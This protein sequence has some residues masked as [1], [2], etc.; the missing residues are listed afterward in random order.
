MKS[1]QCDIATEL[2]R[3]IRDLTDAKEIVE[4]VLP[5]GSEHLGHAERLLRISR[6]RIR[7]ALKVVRQMPTIEVAPSAN[8]E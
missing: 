6:D 5:G 8:D 2:T 1:Q 4:K 3:T 7:K